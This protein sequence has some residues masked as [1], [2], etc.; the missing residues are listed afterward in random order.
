[1]KL[2]AWP[3]ASVTGPNTEVLA[4][5]WLLTTST[6]VSV[7]FPALLTLPLKTS[8]WPGCTGPTGQALL[9]TMAGLFVPAQDA[10]A[11]L[12]TLWPKHLS[13]ARAVRVS[14]YGPHESAGT[15]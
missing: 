15:M 4:A 12:V 11:V 5:G 14:T 2:V 9:T 3:G 13:W 6:L 8:G 1:M 10:V 7:M